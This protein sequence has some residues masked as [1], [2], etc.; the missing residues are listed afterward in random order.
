MNNHDATQ[1]REENLTAESPIRYF[2][3]ILHSSHEKS[4]LDEPTLHKILN[5]LGK[6]E[7]PRDR[8]SLH[9]WLDSRQGFGEAVYRLALA[10]RVKASLIRI[11]V[12]NR[13]K[14]AAML[15]VTLADDIFMSPSSELGPLDTMLIAPENPHKKYSARLLSRV[16]ANL[17]H[18]SLQVVR[19]SGHEIINLTGMSRTESLELMLDY[20]SKMVAPILKQYDPYLIH[21]ALS[22]INNI[23]NYA[24]R[25]IEDQIEKISDNSA[26]REKLSELAEK[27]TSNYQ[28][29]NTVIDIQAAREL[30]LP[31]K[32]IEQY[33]YKKELQYLYNLHESTKKPFI[34][35]L[36]SQEA[37]ELKNHPI[38]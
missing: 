15:L 21:Q 31:I 28:S 38:E 11:V 10:L 4:A 26:R 22:S 6:I 18:M 7:S 14:S 32:E 34:M 3:A 5:L 2:L 30:G 36:D 20:A 23:R 37:E 29:D 35:L 24:E 9:I 27:L 1:N 8:T 17:N 12:P 16:L 13:V 19:D 25:L 33:K